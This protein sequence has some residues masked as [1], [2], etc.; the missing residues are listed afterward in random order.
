MDYVRLD[1]PTNEYGRLEPHF[2]IA[3]AVDRGDVPAWLKAMRR[4]LDRRDRLGR[5]VG[6]IYVPRAFYHRLYDHYETTVDLLGNDLYEQDDE[7][8]YSG[9]VIIPVED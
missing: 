9:A 6:P 8:M 3:R 4:L 7:L 5:F 2:A 1:R